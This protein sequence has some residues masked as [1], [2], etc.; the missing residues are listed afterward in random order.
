MCVCV[1][2]DAKMNIFGVPHPKIEKSNLRSLLYSFSKRRRLP[3]V[4]FSG[5][6]VEGD[7][8]SGFGIFRHKGNI[9]REL[10]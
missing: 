4:Q 2:E 8:R 7:L 9:V 10:D 5:V 1:G 3:K 6:L